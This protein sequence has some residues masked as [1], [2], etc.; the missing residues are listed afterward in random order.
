MTGTDEISE[1]NRLFSL[2]KKS[3]RDAGYESFEVRKDRL[4][5]ALTMAQKYEKE[6]CEAVNSDFGGRN[7]LLTLSLDFV[8]SMTELKHARKCLKGWMKPEK[9]RANFPLNLLGAGGA[10]FREPKG[11]IA[12][13]STWNFPVYNLLGPL[14][15]IVAAG[16][17]C[18]FKANE[19]T[20]ESGKFM[21]RIVAE[22]FNDDEFAVALGGPEVS[23]AVCSLPFDHILFT[24]SERAG[25]LVMAGAAKNL[26]PVT[27]ELGG[28]CPA[29]VSTSANLDDV[30]K[31]VIF[32]KMSNAGQICL[33][34]DYMYVHKSQKE[35]LVSRLVQQAQE[36]FP[37]A[38]ENN[39]YTAIIS[40]QH[41]TRLKGLVDDARTRGAKVTIVDE[42]Q[43]SGNSR[44]LPL[45]IIEN[46]TDDM[47][48]MQEEV[49]GPLLPVLTYEQFDETTKRARML[50]KPLASYYFGSNRQEEEAVLY[51]IPS[52]ST[53]INDVM[54]HCLQ[55]ELPFGGVGASGMGQYHSVEG[56]QEFTNP[57]AVYRQ[58]KIDIGRFL[59]P[60][61]G[62]KTE[63][64][65]R[66]LM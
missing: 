15:G 27:L 51:H 45:H 18:L 62:R 26:T 11:V 40:D 2:Q 44:K 24:G 63:S 34:P 47:A 29:I 6:L 8:G 9:R 53:T 12:N 43:K 50:P 55:E 5:R 19:L 25:R 41:L 20:P 17:R 36:Q 46:V 59:R 52:G 64:L 3:T 48:V 33:A 65:I 49:F 31:K 10:V 58:T 32:G 35:R 61:F 21:K 37:N 54:F 1:L 57:R 23:A 13:I 14:G 60:P 22:Y 16:N 28:K 39:D 7:P 66:K 30:A 4:D 38:A 42:T 56:Y